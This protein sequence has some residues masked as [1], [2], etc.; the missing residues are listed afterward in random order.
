MAGHI[1]STAVLPCSSALA[2]PLPLFLP[3]K[4]GI[5]AQQGEQLERRIARP[6]GPNGTKE[7]CST[8]TGACAWCK[9]HSP[10]S[11]SATSARGK[12]CWARSVLG[13]CHNGRAWAAAVLNGRQ[14]FRGTAGH[15]PSGSCSLDDADRR[16]RLWSE[17]R[18]G[19]VGQQIGSNRCP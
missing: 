12:F 13:P 11:V 6:R 4:R 9:H 16:F 5:L 18:V 8:D 1:P 14:R 2:A 15:Q 19:A 10:P 3:G 17:G 7:L